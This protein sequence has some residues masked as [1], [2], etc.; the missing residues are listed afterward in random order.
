M[1]AFCS[2]LSDCLLE[3]W[4]LAECNQLPS[5][6]TEGTAC[7]AAW[8]QRCLKSE[9]GL[10][11]CLV[12]QVKVLCNLFNESRSDRQSKEVLGEITDYNKRYS[13]EPRR[14]SARSYLPLLSF[15]TSVLTNFAWSLFPTSFLC[16]PPCKIQLVYVSHTASV[17][18]NSST[19]PNDNVLSNSSIT[20][21]TSI[22]S[23]SQLSDSGGVWWT[24]PM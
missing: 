3:T 6:Q 16:S 17:K 15:Y 10:K 18:Q 8:W 13:G 20:Y 19:H 23:H 21:A 2:P 24:R 5:L 11:L 7:M 4:V 22:V 14:V 12:L 1:F 9:H